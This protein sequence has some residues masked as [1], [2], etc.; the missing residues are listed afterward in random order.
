MLLTRDVW[1][2]ILQ[3][4][5]IS[6]KYKHI[7]KEFNHFFVLSVNNHKLKKEIKKWIFEHMCF[8]GN[9]NVRYMK[10]ITY[11]TWG[12]GFLSACKGGQ[13]KLVEQMFKNARNFKINPYNYV[14]KG[15]LNACISGNIETIQFIIDTGWKFKFRKAMRILCDMGHINA[16]E[17]L[18]KNHI[19]EMEK[20]A[21][22]T[23]FIYVCQHMC[24]NNQAN[25]TQRLIELADFDDNFV[26]I[27]KD[28]ISCKTTYWDYGLYLATYRHLFSSSDCLC[29]V[30]RMIDCGATYIPIKNNNFSLDI[31]EKPRIS[32]YI[33]DFIKQLKHIPKNN[34]RYN[35]YKTYML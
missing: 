27:L 5:C 34:P 33:N 15:F 17:Y 20:N 21:I 13:V 24:N 18:I 4:S 7:C 32:A 6:Y 1:W 10:Y 26:N 31:L 11:D 25:I 29:V 3:N 2:T 30:K 8:I 19:T 23:W 9:V 22:T 16:I 12:I 35:R 14:C 28:K